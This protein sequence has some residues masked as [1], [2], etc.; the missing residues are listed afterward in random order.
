MVRNNQ[1][2]AIIFDMD[3]VITNTMPDH[4]RSWKTVLKS[5]GVFVTYEDIY[6]REGQ[7]GISSVRE[8]FR[9]YQKDYDDKKA[10]MILR[11]KEDNLEERHHE[12]QPR[13]DDRASVVGLSGLH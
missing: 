8:L 6:K 12:D 5:E 7:P 1:I 13:I 3:G 2:E 10:A 4:Y 11:K 9:E